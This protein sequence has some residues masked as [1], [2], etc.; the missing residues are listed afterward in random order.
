MNIANK[1]IKASYV[2]SQQSILWGVHRVVRALHVMQLQVGSLD[3][4]A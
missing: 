3:L 2:I 1:P 4:D